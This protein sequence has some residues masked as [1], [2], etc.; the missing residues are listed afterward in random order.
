MLPFMHKIMMH[1]L[2]CRTFASIV[3]KQNCLNL[4]QVR[5]RV[6]QIIRSLLSQRFNQ[7]STYDESPAVLYLVAEN[8]RSSFNKPV[9][10]LSVVGPQLE[11]MPC[12]QNSS[13]SFDAEVRLDLLE[14]SGAHEMLLFRRIMDN[15]HG[16]APTLRK[17]RD[18]TTEKP[19]FLL[20]VA[21]RG[22][23]VYSV[24]KAPGDAANVTKGVSKDAPGKS[25]TPCIT[26][27]TVLTMVASWSNTGSDIAEI[28]EAANWVLATFFRHFNFYVLLMW[29]RLL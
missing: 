17:G 20:T 22:F 19:F 14:D 16:A 5:P 23:E 21:K 6:N 24:C 12:M 18:L 29:G 15:A 2:L 4:V 26:P 7:F 10:K 13:L 8:L 28:S 25:L 3:H 1:T 11:K 9:A 27:K